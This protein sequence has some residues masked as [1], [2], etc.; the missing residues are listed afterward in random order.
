ML[1]VAGS[2]EVGFN[3]AMLACWWMKLAIEKLAKMLAL[4]NTPLYKNRIIFI[5]NSIFTAAQVATLFFVDMLILLWC[6]WLHLII[7][8]R[9]CMCCRGT[10]APRSLPFSHD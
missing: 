1:W 10:V 6:L 5:L 8:H 3:D 4:H 9:V 2:L 7:P